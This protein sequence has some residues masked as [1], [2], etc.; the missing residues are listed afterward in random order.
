MRPKRKPSRARGQ[1][2]PIK[3]SPQA[4]SGKKDLIPKDQRL[5]MGVHSVSEAFRVRPHAIRKMWL[6]QN[7]HDNSELL[8]FSNLAEKH[9]I[10][11]EMKSAE[12]LN[13]MTSGHQGLG[14]LVDESPELDWETLKST[15]P[16]QL[17][18]LDGIEDPHNLGAILRTAWLI[19]VKAI[20]IPEVRAAGLSPTTCKVASGGAEHVPV[21]Y[22]SSLPQLVERLKALDFWVYGLAAEGTQDIWS[23]QLEGKVVWALGSEEKGLRKPLA[24]S[25]DQLVKIHQLSSQA[26]YNVSVAAAMAMGESARQLGYLH[27]T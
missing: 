7:F 24:R 12:I 4:N 21:V 27:S 23:L 16:Q 14:V 8:E 1:G 11:I 15:N 9:R 18:I 10:P 5:V 2:A 22:E 13:R 19:G 25:C 17:L 20:F 3:R 26:S 6:R